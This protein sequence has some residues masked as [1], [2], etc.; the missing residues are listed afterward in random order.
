M[1]GRGLGGEGVGESWRE[2][3]AVTSSFL[4][5]SERLVSLPGTQMCEVWCGRRKTVGLWKL[6]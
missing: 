1:K 5:V 4:A 2:V 6:F 3:Q